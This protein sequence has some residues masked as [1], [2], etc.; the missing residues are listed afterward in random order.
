MVFSG[1]V[2][3]KGERDDRQCHDEN[4]RTALDNAGSSPAIPF[5]LRVRR[6][7]VGVI[8]CI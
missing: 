1:N 7:V 4:L 8:A 3:V 2:S 5:I 6:A